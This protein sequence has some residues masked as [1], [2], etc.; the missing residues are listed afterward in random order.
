LGGAVFHDLVTGRPAISTG[1]IAA[2][3]VGAE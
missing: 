3:K 1:T 2:P